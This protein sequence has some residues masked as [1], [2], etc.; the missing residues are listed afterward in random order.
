VND[1]KEGWGAMRP[2]D[3]VFHYYSDGTSLC[4]KIGF[5]GGPL[6]DANPA[7]TIA[8]KTDCKPC[9]RKLLARQE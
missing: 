8:Q 5:Y 4:R 6:D 3:R 2:G 9:F 1:K 7:Q